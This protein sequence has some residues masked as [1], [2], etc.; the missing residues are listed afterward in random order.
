M[1]LSS[2]FGDGGD[3][4]DHK[5]IIHKSRLSS[6]A[7]SQRNF[8]MFS[9]ITL[10]GRIFAVSSVFVVILMGRNVGSPKGFTAAVDARVPGR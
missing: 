4:T 8:A 3:V 5:N 9:A 1:I 6:G 2:E 7:G 10:T